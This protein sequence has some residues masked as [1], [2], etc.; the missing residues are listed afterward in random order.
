MKPSKSRPPTP[1]PTPIPT[2]AAVLK[3]L[4]GLSPHGSPRAKT[5]LI[6]TDTVAVANAVLATAELIEFDTEGG[7]DTVVE[8]M[9]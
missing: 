8:S 5:W 1:A 9:L 6:M 7:I 3:P 2:L 4:A